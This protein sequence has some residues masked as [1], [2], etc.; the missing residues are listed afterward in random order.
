MFHCLLTKLFQDLTRILRIHLLGI[1]MVHGK[2]EELACVTTNFFSVYHYIYALRR[3]LVAT[4][5]IK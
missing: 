2:T 1:P 3:S 4:F 5:L